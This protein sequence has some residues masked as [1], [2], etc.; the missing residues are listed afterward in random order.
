MIAKNIVLQSAGSLSVAILALLMVILQIMAGQQHY[1]QSLEPS[2]IQA[3]HRQIK[4]TKWQTYN[5]QP[6]EA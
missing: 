2:A 4:E 5:Y 6:L 1:I 3:H